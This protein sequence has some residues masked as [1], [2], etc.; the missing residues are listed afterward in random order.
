MH[1]WRGLIYVWASSAAWCNR[2][3][4]KSIGIIHMY[5]QIYIYIAVLYI[6]IYICTYIAVLYICIYRCIYIYTYIYAYIYEGGAYMCGHL[7]RYD[8]IGYHYCP[9]VLYICIY[10]CTQIYFHIYIYICINTRGAR[11]CVSISRGII[12][13]AITIIHHYYTCFSVCTYVY[14]YIYIC[15]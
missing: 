11:I 5:I 1:I 3:S 13:K 9:S 15:V 7:L 10:L 6:C 12:F 2:L 8:V 4:L 14:T